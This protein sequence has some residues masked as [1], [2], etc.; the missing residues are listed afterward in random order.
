MVTENSMLPD[1]A[2][3]IMTLHQSEHW[4]NLDHGQVFCALRTLQATWMVFVCILVL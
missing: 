2:G 1:S 3:E 4:L